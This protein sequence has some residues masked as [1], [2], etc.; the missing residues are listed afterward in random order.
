M[1][2]EETST[3]ECRSKVRNPVN[4]RNFLILFDICTKEKK[5]S[6][7]TAEAQL[8]AM[9]Y[10]LMPV[11]FRIKGTCCMSRLSI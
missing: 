2:T 8:I 11:L 3:E 1:A 4:W 6:Y 9:V 10:L 7:K 5:F